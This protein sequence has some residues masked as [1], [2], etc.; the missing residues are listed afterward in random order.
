[1]NYARSRAAVCCFDNQRIYAFYG[2]DTHNK[3][4]KIIEK[5]NTEKNIWEV[6]QIYNDLVGIEVS[7]AG[8]IQ[9]NDYQILIFGGFHEGIHEENLIPSK[10]IMTFNVINDTIRILKNKLPIDFCLEGSL[11]PIIHDN[12]LY[13]IG[14]FFK[15]SDKNLRMT[16]F[17]YALNMNENGVEIKSILSMKTRKA[18]RESRKIGN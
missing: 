18:R 3:N 2:T 10:K 12:N 5:Y 16:D 15:N 6:V 14:F 17:V 11:P 8:A 7:C 13:A 9:I 1:L 4:V